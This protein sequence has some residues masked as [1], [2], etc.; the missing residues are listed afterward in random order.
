[1][2][3]VAPHD[4][5]R[6]KLE[7]LG[8][9]ALGDNE[10]LA[11]VIGSGSREAGALALANR[12]LAQLGGLRGLVRAD[13]S[14]L[15]VVPGIGRA[16]AAQV[17]AAIELG[18]RTLAGPADERRQLVS[19]AEIAAFL[20]PQFGASLV[21]QFGV[22]L[23]DTKLRVL[24]IRLVSVGSLDTTVAHPREVFREAAITGA[25][26]V[27][28]FHTHPSGDPRPS[29]DDLALTE[30]LVHAGAI[31]GITVVDHLILSDRLY[32]SLRNSE[33]AQQLGLSAWTRARPV[34]AAGGE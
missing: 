2:K 22:V 25:A 4:R 6:E 14:E 17:R 3:D 9:S 21:E 16:R 27:V 8:P 33:H 32:F 18:R 24:R 7:R 20:L 5:P 29:P 28:L 23:L 10:L 11:L 13:T 30:R 15:R 19:P 34:P 26:A 1:M 12:L 31:L